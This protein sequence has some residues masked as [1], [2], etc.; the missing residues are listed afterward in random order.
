V[1]PVCIGYF[2]KVPCNDLDWH[3]LA[4]RYFSLGV[5]YRIRVQTYRHYKIY[6]AKGPPSNLYS[7]IR[8]TARGKIWAALSGAFCIEN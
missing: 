7:P 1:T 5:S 4:T 6:M 8:R 2:E 3:W